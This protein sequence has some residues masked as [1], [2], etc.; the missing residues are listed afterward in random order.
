MINVAHK[1]QHSLCTK[2]CSM[3]KYVAMHKDC[4]ERAAEGQAGSSRCT[5]MVPSVGIP[6]L[7]PQD[8][9]FMDAPFCTFSL[10]CQKQVNMSKCLPYSFVRETVYF[11]S[12]VIL[13]I[14][15]ICLK[16][17]NDIKENNT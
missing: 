4:L 9:Y 14:N 8:F 7:Q 16:A 17:L 12:I 5:G 13:K 2:E 6:C 11:V 3:L 15:D 10:L 1:G